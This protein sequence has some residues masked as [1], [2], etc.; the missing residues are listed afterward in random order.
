MTKF[1]DIQYKKTIDKYDS[2]EIEIIFSSKEY[3]LNH[4]IWFVVL[5]K[6]IYSYTSKFF[7]L[8]RLMLLDK[9]I[10]DIINNN[11]Y[12]KNVKCWNLLCSRKCTNNLESDDIL[13]ALIFISNIINSNIVHDNIWNNKYNKN[14]IINL[15]KILID[16]SHK[17]QYIYIPL[18]VNIYSNLTLIQL[19]IL[20]R[21]FQ[22]KF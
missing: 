22:E 14:I 18:L 21:Y 9:I 1:R 19:E 13:N 11:H 10:Q 17:K 3:L 6:T 16:K 4:S 7:N 2:W 15:T 8:D 20:N 5:I 12:F